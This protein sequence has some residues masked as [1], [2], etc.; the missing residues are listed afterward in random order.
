M[1]I[2]FLF[3][4]FVLFFLLKTS[5]SFN[6]DQNL[7]AFLDGAQGH[8]SKDRQDDKGGVQARIIGGQ[9]AGPSEFP[10]FT[11]VCRGDQKSKVFCGGR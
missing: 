1:K 8:V 5:N 11:A 7:E 6:I 4:S 3:Y 9:D 2:L 10:F